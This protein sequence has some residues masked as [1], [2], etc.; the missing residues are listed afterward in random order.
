MIRAVRQLVG[1]A[2]GVAA[3]ALPAWAMFH[4]IR[5]GSCGDVGQATCPDEVGL[6]I[7]ALVGSF[8]V[9]CPAAIFIAGSDRATGQLL[10]LGPILLLTPLSFVAGIVVSLVGESADPDSQW[11]GWV[12][13]GIA[14][15][16]LIRVVIGLVRRLG[17]APTLTAHPV[18]AAQMQTLA[19][20]LQQVQAAK[21]TPDPGL[22][23]RLRRLDELHASGVID[24][25]E[26]R[27]RRDEILAE[28]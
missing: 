3:V 10:L 23:A 28:I 14:A 16:I 20:A 18:Q 27:R 21:A 19:T 5:Q 9:L 15:L 12:L 11:I 25:A 26:R 13:G 1:A 4:L 8:V 17:R 24:D 2:I 6:W 7:L 22:A